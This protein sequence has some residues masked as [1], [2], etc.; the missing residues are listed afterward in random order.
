M[1]ACQAGQLVSELV[2]WSFVTLVFVCL[3]VCLFVDEELV[4]E[5]ISCFWGVVIGCV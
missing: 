5:R 3:S 4:V 1:Y 2:G